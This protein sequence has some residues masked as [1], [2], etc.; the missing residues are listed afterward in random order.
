[1]PGL[2]LLCLL[3]G[4]GGSALALADGLTSARG[5]VA[6]VG[7]DIQG[8]P[9]PQAQVPQLRAR[10][11]DLLALLRQTGALAPL[12][13]FAINQSIRLF[14]QPAALSGA[15]SGGWAHLLV[16][17]VDPARS[18]K[19]PASGGLRGYGE[20]PAI[21]MRVNDQG[22]LFGYPVGKDAHGDYYQLLV[23][24]R[25]LQGMPVLQVG[26][27]DVVVVHKAGRKPFAHVSRQRYLEG[28]LAGEREHIASLQQQLAEATDAESRHQLEQFIRQ[29]QG[30]AAQKQATLDAM[31]D[32]ERRSP[33]CQ[34]SASRGLF[35]PCSDPG[36]VYYV[37][38]EPGYFQ[39]GLP[40]S[41]V[42]LLT[43][44]VVGKDFLN[45]KTLGLKVRQ[46]V[47]QLD[48]AALQRSLD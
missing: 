20:G 38:F 33:T 3:L 42:Q 36:V 45:D 21:E 48:L 22:A 35:A 18:A 24:P 39:P 4:L 1:M 7:F 23:K 34:S 27:K 43:I 17:R 25:R 11:D 16:R 6:P 29:W 15:P 47:A 26:S 37:T 40:P 10:L 5:S 12:Q 30:T 2:R 19:D 9:L 13:G 46:A 28:L 8:S 14:E 31:S 41:S 32:A 44:S